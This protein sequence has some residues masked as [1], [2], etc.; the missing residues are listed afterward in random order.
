MVLFYFPEWFKIQSS[1]T[2]DASLGIL[3][4]FIFS[5]SLVNFPMRLWVMAETYSVSPAALRMHFLVIF[6]ADGQ[7]LYMQNF[8]VTLLGKPQILS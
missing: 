4:S 6:L 3:Q 8:V 7:I 2:W 5:N 1:P